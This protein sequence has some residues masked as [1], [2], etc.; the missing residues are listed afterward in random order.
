MQCAVKSGMYVMNVYHAALWHSAP[1][2]MISIRSLDNAVDTVD[3][4]KNEQLMNKSRH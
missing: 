3:P 4:P 2:R 1:H